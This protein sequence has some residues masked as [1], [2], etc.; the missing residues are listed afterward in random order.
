MT[1]DRIHASSEYRNT[2]L[3]AS[4]SLVSPYIQNVLPM[5][6]SPHGMKQL[7]ARILAVSCNFR[8]VA[9]VQVALALR[10]CARVLG[11]T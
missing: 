2:Y 3:A 6:V 4:D 8:P 9:H 7:L 10:K 1:L 11:S 5:S